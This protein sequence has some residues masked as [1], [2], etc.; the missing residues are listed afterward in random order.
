MKKRI[1]WNKGKKGIP[2][3]TRRKMS[4]VKKGKKRIPFTE[5]TRK[6]MSQAR[7]GMKFSQEH[8]RNLTISRNKR[9]DKPMLGKKHTE[10]FKRRMRI[11]KLG[12][13]ASEKTKKKQSRSLKKAYKNPKLRKKLSD[14]QMGR[15]VLPATRRKIGAKNRMNYSTPERQEFFRE[16]RLHQVFP[17]K[18]TIIEKILQNGLRKNGIKFQKHKPILGQPDLFIE[19]NICIFADGDYWHGWLYLN[20]KRYDNAKKLN[21]EFFEKRIQRDKRNTQLLKRQGYEVLRFWG[22][23]IRENPEKCLQKII[24]AIK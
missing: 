8:R 15:K 18:D 11:I 10:E 17:V 20:G 19:P 6:R 3:E 14:A 16:K 7:K 2:E 12:T 9:T 24:K 22:H 1:P 13:K 23:E 21:N 5:K 4:E